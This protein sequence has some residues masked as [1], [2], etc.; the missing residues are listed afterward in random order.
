[1]VGKNTVYNNLQL[2]FNLFLCYFEG[3]SILF[4]SVFFNPFVGYGESI[5]DFLT[6]GFWGSVLGVSVFVTS[7]D[8]INRGYKT[9]CVFRGK[10]DA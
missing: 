9:E 2:Y 5:K 7:N 3:L 8:L 6:L 1:M 10:T 4:V